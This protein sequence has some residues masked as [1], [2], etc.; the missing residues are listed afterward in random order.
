MLNGVNI[1][2][3]AQGH[4]ATDS[5]IRTGKGTC[6]MRPWVLDGKITPK[7][8]ITF[9]W[10]LV[11]TKPNAIHSVTVLG[12]V[13]Q[14]AW[15]HYYLWLKQAMVEKQLVRKPTSEDM[16]VQSPGWWPRWDNEILSHSLKHIFLQFNQEGILRSG[17]IT[18][19]ILNTGSV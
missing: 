7:I 14:C 19:C 17:D 5:T 16:R 3:T 13:K 1:W 6:M 18:P 2:G 15:W 12:D 8:F 4:L 11:L 10:P 9:D